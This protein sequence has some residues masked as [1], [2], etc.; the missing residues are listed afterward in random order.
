MGLQQ[1]LPLTQSLWFLQPEVVGTYLPGTGT[2]GWGTWCGAETPHS[3]DIL[4][5][6]LFTTCECGTSLFCICVPPTSLD[7]CGLFNFIVVR[8]PFNLISDVSEP[9][10]FYI[11]AVILM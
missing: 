7:E 3:Q 5:E 1:F 8:L 6:F 9:W 2:L 4:S 11:L 10:L